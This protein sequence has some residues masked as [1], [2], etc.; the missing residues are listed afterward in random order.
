MMPSESW[1]PERLRLHEL[2]LAKAGPVTVAPVWR[3]A[4]S[5]C[6][7]FKVCYSCPT[8]PDSAR[9]NVAQV[10]VRHRAMMLHWQVSC[11]WLCNNDMPISCPS[12]PEWC[13][14]HDRDGARKRQEHVPRPRGPQVQQ[15]RRLVTVQCN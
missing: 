15:A 4:E 5:R 1:S 3:Q 2:A 10:A 9:Y 12:Q 14:H 6:V 13:W 8:V 11:Q 7:F